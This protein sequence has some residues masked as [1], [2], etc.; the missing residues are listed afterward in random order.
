[1]Q[2]LPKT[3]LGKRAVG[4]VVLWPLLTISGSVLA[5]GL[6]AGVPA[7]DGLVDDLRARPALAVAM[8]IGIASGLASV[9][10]SLIAIVKN[11]ERSVL[12]FI[13]ALLGLLLVALLIGELF[14][15]H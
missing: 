10:N 5:E 8:L 6:Y 14:I 15:Q 11:G 3:Q 13:S 7:G 4:L 1:M 2:F 12:V 9:P